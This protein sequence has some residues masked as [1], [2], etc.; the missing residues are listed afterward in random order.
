MLPFDEQLEIGDLFFCSN[1]A[2]RFASALDQVTFKRPGVVG[3]VDVHK[4]VLCHGA[5][6]GFGAGDPCPGRWLV[7]LVA[8]N[9]LY[10]AKG[11]YGQDGKGD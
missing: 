3:A 4:V 7:R 1:Y 6:A 10:L 9:G 11:E 2:D 8:G 5:P